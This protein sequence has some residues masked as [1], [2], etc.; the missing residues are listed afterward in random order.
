MAHNFQ[1]ALE[2]RGKTD[3]SLWQLGIHF[4]RYAGD[5]GSA[6]RNCSRLRHTS[7]D[8]TPAE[9]TVKWLST[10]DF[11]RR[12]GLEQYTFALED[13]GHA[14]WQDWKHMSKDDLKNRVKMPEKEATLCH[15]VLTG[16]Q[17]RPDIL[18]MFQHPEFVDLK[19]MF[20]TRFPEA[21]QGD[22]QAFA[23]QLTDELGCAAV[24]VLQVQNFLESVDRPA[25]ALGQALT[26]GLPSSE[27]A[28][29]ALKRPE[30]C[31]PPP[32][33]DAWVH[34]WLKDKDLAQY[35]GAFLGQELSTRED[36]LRAS[37]DVPALEAMGVNK[38]GHRCKILAMIEE[39]R[40][41]P[42]DAA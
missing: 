12:L 31:P 7:E 23:V 17:D 32:E 10:F 37:L 26:E 2:N 20:R 33:S 36:V 29:E 24:S 35:S 8:R 4:K 21:P 30:P 16:S 41:T 1:E 15:A 18:R 42:A 34:T 28:R 27:L 5:P 38:I 6:L 3:V 14:L 39:Q 9:K 40:E 25:N 22:A 11:L 13:E 19:D